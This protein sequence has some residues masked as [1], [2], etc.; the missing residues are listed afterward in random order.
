[1]LSLISW[2]EVCGEHEI[3]PRLIQDLVEKFSGRCWPRSPRE[4]VYSRN[5]GN[6]QRIVLPNWVHRR[7][8][9]QSLA[10]IL[11]NFKLLAFLCH[12]SKA[13]G[14]FSKL[15]LLQNSWRVRNKV[16]AIF[17]LCWFG[18]NATITLK[19]TNIIPHT[20]SITQGQPA[21]ETLG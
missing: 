10:G 14:F 3:A 13:L 2:N 11:G 12:R 16:F 5:S 4:I 21:N 7:K 20:R 6:F 9:R 15:S 18:K 17:K 19:P 8:F 1:M